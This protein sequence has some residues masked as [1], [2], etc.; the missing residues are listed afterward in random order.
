MIKLFVFVFT[1]LM[2]L[3]HNNY[4]LLDGNE[5]PSKGCIKD[6]IETKAEKQ[7]R[8]YDITKD[9]MEVVYEENEPAIWSYQGDMRREASLFTLL[10]IAYFESG[11]RKDIDYGIGKMSRGDNGSS[12]CLMQIHLGNG[13]TKEGWTGEDLVNDRKKCL[14]TGYRMVKSSFGSCSNLPLDERLTM[15]AS[16][17]CGIGL[18]ESRARIGLAKHWFT[19]APKIKDQEVFNNM[20]FNIVLPNNPDEIIFG[21]KPTSDL[22]SYHD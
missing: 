14:R 12:Y 20:K 17:K 16:G 8:F 5:P 2:S 11:F 13:K 10:S 19:R 1:L 15:Y 18:P 4:C 7:Q 21:R 22:L 9:I 3:Q 6:A